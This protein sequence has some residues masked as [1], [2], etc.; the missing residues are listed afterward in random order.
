MSARELINTFTLRNV[1][2]VASIGGPNYKFGRTYDIK[3]RYVDHVTKNFRIFDLR[4]VEPT[5][6]NVIVERL[7]NKELKRMGILCKHTKHKELFYLDDESR[8]KEIHFLL[9]NIIEDNPS[10]NERLLRKYNIL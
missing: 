10:Y 8:L 4:I 1:V 6:N 5:D 2:Y 3:K 9:K 7:F